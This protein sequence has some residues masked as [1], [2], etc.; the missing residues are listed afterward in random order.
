VE[1]LNP[2]AFNIDSL[3]YIVLIGSFAILSSFEKTHHH[4]I[5]VAFFGFTFMLLTCVAHVDYVRHYT[6]KCMYYCGGQGHI[7]Q[8]GC[9]CFNGQ[10]FA[11]I[12]NW[13]YRSHL[14]GFF[15]EFQWFDSTLMMNLIVMGGLMIGSFFAGAYWGNKC[16][17]EL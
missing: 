9:G 5:P 15:M 17:R 12:S 11:Q 8:W 2:Y 7:E 13:P 10:M 16:K 4:A 6:E 14:G 3:F 1:F